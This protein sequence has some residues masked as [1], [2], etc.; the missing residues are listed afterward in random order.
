[1]SDPTDGSVGFA[2]AAGVR[3]PTP[4]QGHRSSLARRVETCVAGALAWGLAVFGATQ[5][6]RIDLPLG[7]GICGPWGCAAAPSALVGYHLFWLLMVAP[8]ATLA[9]A[10]LP[11]KTAI[12]LS[13]AMLATGVCATAA[14]AVGGA[15]AWL[16][17]G[18]EPRYATQRAL[19]VI[20]TT[21]D[22]P[23]LSV[24]L[25]G[26]V[27][28]LIARRSDRPCTATG[29]GPPCRVRPTDRSG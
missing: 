22:L 24:A 5:L 20:A 21:P 17:E 26:G 19:F 9:S 25:A 12:R 11:R 23:V 13:T 1:M 27:A 2:E 29:P 15:V 16:R 3:S 14:L 4:Q 8:F 10:T 6:H 18:G 28:T 7:D